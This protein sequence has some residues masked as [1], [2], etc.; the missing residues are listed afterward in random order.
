MEDEHTSLG[1]WAAGC[2]G[3]L[4][5][6]LRLDLDP[7]HSVDAFLAALILLVIVVCLRLGRN[8]RMII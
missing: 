8:R 4:P 3:S 1:E 6:H 7:D 5:G 2:Q